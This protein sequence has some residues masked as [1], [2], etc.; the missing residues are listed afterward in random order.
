MLQGEVHPAGLGDVPL[1]GVGD[2]GGVGGRVGGQPAGEALA[3]AG[4]FDAGGLIRLGGEPVLLQAADGIRHRGCVA[5][6]EGLTDGGEPG[7]ESAAQ[8]RARRHGLLR[9]ELPGQGGRPVEHDASGAACFASLIGVGATGAVP[10]GQQRGHVLLGG[11]SEDGHQ[12]VELVTG[13]RGLVAEVAF[14]A[15]PRPVRLG[16]GLGV[17]P[18]GRAHQ[19]EGG[20]VRA[21]LGVDEGEQGASGEARLVLLAEEGGQSGA[22]GTAQGEE[23]FGGSGAGRPVQQGLGV[24]PVVAGA[25]RAALGVVAAQAHAALGER[26]EGVLAGQPAAGHG[27]PAAGRGGVEQGLGGP[28]D[29][30]E[31]WVYLPGA[32]RLT[33][34]VPA[35]D[36]VDAHLV[37]AGEDRRVEFVLLPVS[38]D[39]QHSGPGAAACQM[40]EDDFV[41]GERG[42]RDRHAGRAAL[43][44]GG[45]GGPVPLRCGP[46]QHDPTP[47]LAVPREGGGKGRLGGQ[48][49]GDGRGVQSD[50]A[51][52]SGDG[53]RHSMTC[54]V[55][56]MVASGWR[57]ASSD[58]SAWR[59]A[60]ARRTVVLRRPDF[61][62]VPPLAGE[63]VSC[64]GVV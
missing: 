59:S 49:L 20:G 64:D 34:D 61:R 58:S 40:V 63:D 43:A 31:P 15:A 2:G 14:G 11:S 53:V 8:D 47:A 39:D 12:D 4:A 3:H 33:D 21:A 38:E 19:A 29:V 16:G 9:A 25:A 27:R 22:F 44:P 37:D 46:Q 57:A 26:G 6:R 18:Q 50:R 28:V 1:Q 54:Q 62:A 13:R 36:R 51:R 35:V 30:L 23:P 42:R 56:S 52:D 32:E 55:I 17:L 41:D 24:E 48:I 5:R 45:L 10:G 60:T 7:L